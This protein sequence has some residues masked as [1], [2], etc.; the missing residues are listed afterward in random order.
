VWQSDRLYN[1][2]TELPPPLDVETEPILTQCIAARAALAELRK[3]AE[4]IPN[5]SVLL[6]ILPLLEAGA[7]SEIENIVTTAD[8]LVQHASN[9]EHA[10]AATRE[11]LRY[12]RALFE[13]DRAARLGGERRGVPP[14][15]G[16][17]LLREKLAN[18]ERFM[19]EA[20]EQ[21]DSETTGSAR[22]PVVSA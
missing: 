19:H 6:G 15:V 13:G 18:W 10:D 2:L 21:H 4:L 7:S 22:P 16:E 5:Q 20:T 12:R 9:E 1:G 8:R 11:A 14:T 17:P 3:A